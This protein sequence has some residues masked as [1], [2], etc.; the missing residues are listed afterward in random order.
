[1]SS[2]VLQQSCAL[3]PMDTGLAAARLTFE[4][5]TDPTAARKLAKSLLK[6]GQMHIL[7]YICD[8]SLLS[9]AFILLVNWLF[10]IACSKLTTATILSC[11]PA[12]LDWSC[13]QTWRVLA[14][15]MSLLLFF[16]T[17]VSLKA[18]HHAVCLRSMY[19]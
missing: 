8:I 6:V 16:I 11:G 2:E 1:M 18:S 9:T 7:C 15:L 5:A 19:E 12:M 4:G 17:A 10:L 14:R 13:K 3:F